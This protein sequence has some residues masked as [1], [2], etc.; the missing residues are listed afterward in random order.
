[1]EAEIIPME[2]SEKSPMEAEMSPVLPNLLPNLLTSSA[3][4]AKGRNEKQDGEDQ[5]AE[6]VEPQGKGCCRWPRWFPQSRRGRRLC[7]GCSCCFSFIFLAAAVLIPLL[8]PRD[9]QWFVKSTHSDPSQLRDM[10]EAMLGVA[11]TGKVPPL[12]M[13]VVVHVY[14]PNFVTADA[15]SVTSAVLF[16]GK[17]ISSVIGQPTVLQ[18]RSWSDVAVTVTMDLDV[19][20]AKT[21]G[22]YAIEHQMQIPF[23][24]AATAMVKAFGFIP[25]ICDVSC[26][27]L[28]DGKK[29]LTDPTNSV[30]SHVCRYPCSLA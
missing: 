7:I 8:W 19:Y 13:D 3:V 1:M 5:D 10:L 16:Q 29:M 18:G 2:L 27:L 12:V 14:N 28:V 6:A 23:H 25:M 15:T 4:E 22:Q 30:L 26:D 9:P 17:Q 21:I 24:A 11:N 20:T